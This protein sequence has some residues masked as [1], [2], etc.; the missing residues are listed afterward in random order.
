M[1]AQAETVCESKLCHTVIKKTVAL[2]SVQDAGDVDVHRRESPKYVKNHH[3]MV[4]L[5][6]HP[7]SASYFQCSLPRRRP[8]TDI[9]AIEIITFFRPVICPLTRRVMHMDMTGF[10]WPCSG[11]TM[12]GGI[13]SSHVMYCPR[14]KVF[15][16]SQHQMKDKPMDD[17]CIPEEY[18]MLT[19]PLISY[20]YLS[21]QIMWLEL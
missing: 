9:N 11:C 15:G 20:I 12:E 3:T 13:N 4:T 5:A 18:K 16:D 1:I 8:I 2:P 6:L 14:S 7:V 17:K 10:L 19:L 21:S